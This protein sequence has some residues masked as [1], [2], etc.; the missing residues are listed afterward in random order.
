MHTLGLCSCVPTYTSSWRARV[1]LALSYCIFWQ[2]V[3]AT[4]GQVTFLGRGPCCLTSS[5][6]QRKA[7]GHSLTCLAVSPHCTSAKVIFLL[8]LQCAP[9][10]LHLHSLCSIPGLCNWLPL[11]ASSLNITHLSKQPNVATESNKMSGFMPQRVFFF[12][13]SLLTSTTPIWLL[14]LCLFVCLFLLPSD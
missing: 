5:R 9:G 11:Q 1:F 12:S 2:S 8:S 4:L 7:A 6:S 13:L 10:L 14:L 3:G